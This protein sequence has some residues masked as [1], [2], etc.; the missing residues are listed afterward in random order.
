MERPGFVG[1]AHYPQMVELDACGFQHAQDLHR[2]IR[3]LGLEQRLRGQPPQASDRLGITHLR[4]HPVEHGEAGDDFVPFLQGL[5]LTRIEAAALVGKAHQLQCIGNGPRPCRGRARGEQI[6]LAKLCKFAQ[7]S[8]QF[9]RVRAGVRGVD[10]SEQPVERD[11]WLGA[12]A[13]L[14]IEP[15]AARRLGLACGDEGRAE[16]QAGAPELYFAPGKF[17]DEAGCLHQRV[18]VERRAERNVERQRAFI[19]MRRTRQHRGRRHYRPERADQRLALLGEVG[20]DNAY[21]RLWIGFEPRARPGGG[22][23]DLVACIHAG[24][25]KHA[26]FAPLLPG[27]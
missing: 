12:A 5:V 14:E 17:E 7:A 25:A 10:S 18:A 26:R 3:R 20:D 15:R 27:D 11:R 19:R 13:Q 16:Q 22:P 2:R 9:R 23:L 8:R 1:E 6:G 24:N 21:S 4:A